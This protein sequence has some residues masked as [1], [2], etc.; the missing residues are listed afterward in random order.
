MKPWRGSGCPCWRSR[1][2]RIGSFRG[3]SGGGSRR[4]SAARGFEC[5]EDCGHLP[6]IEHPDLLAEEILRFTEG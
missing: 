2:G 5:L 6:M 1:G 3:P 4:R